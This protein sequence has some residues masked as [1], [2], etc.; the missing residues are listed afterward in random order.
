MT[1]IIILVVP[2]VLLIRTAPIAQRV[3]FV[4]GAEIVTPVPVKAKKCL[5]DLLFMAV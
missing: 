4:T 2:P 1:I 3:R 5:Q